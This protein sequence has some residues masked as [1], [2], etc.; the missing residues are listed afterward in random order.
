MS[1]SGHMTTPDDYQSMAAKRRADQFP[2]PPAGD[3][4]PARCPLCAQRLAFMWQ[5]AI[6]D[7]TTHRS[8]R[9][10]LI[11]ASALLVYEFYRGAQYAPVEAMLYLLLVLVGLLAEHPRKILFCENCSFVAPAGH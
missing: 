6:A 7:Q 1:P 5:S 8:V 11:C 2:L 3:D 10:I 4:I 9:T